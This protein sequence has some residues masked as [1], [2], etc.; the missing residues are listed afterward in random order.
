MLRKKWPHPSS[1]LLLQT[2]EPLPW[3]NQPDFQYKEH[4]QLRP[5]SF[6]WFLVSWIFVQFGGYTHQ[7][8]GILRRETGRFTYIISLQILE[9]KEMAFPLLQLHLKPRKQ[10]R[11]NGEKWGGDRQ[12]DISQTAWHAWQLAPGPKIKSL[13]ISRNRWQGASLDLRSVHT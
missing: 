9:E 5:F 6:E 3:L 1:G 2:G 13:E 10:K 8:L 12:K 7:C 11:A 4:E